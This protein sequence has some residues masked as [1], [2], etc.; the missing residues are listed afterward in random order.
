M[1]TPT[2]TLLALA[3]LS[4]RRQ[5][6]RN[7][8]VI[9]GS[10][11]PDLAIFL[12]APYQ[13]L[14]NGVS[15]E[16]MWRELYFQAPMQN[17]IAWFNSVPIYM[18]LAIIGLFAR[19]TVWGKLLLVFAAAALIHIA[20]DLP[21]HAE[22]AYRHF[23]PITDWRFFSPLSYWD[24]NHHARWVGTV[25]VLL[26]GGCIALLWRR[27]PAVWVKISLSLLALFYIAV[28]AFIVVRT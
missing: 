4:R 17:L 8:A 22:D 16:E 28:L 27:H 20:T 21:V 18:G 7:A 5:P 14:V 9:A 25:E 13:S 26:A 6:K 23:W 12:W 11:I 19:G 24:S 1:N 3:L 10:L 2:H 15:G